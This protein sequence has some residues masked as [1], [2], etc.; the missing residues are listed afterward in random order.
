MI[1][2]VMD[3]TK[4]GRKMPRE[5]GVM[6]YRSSCPGCLKFEISPRRR[7]G[8]RRDPHRGNCQRRSVDD[9]LRKKNHGLWL[10]VLAFART[11][12]GAH[13]RLPFPGNGS[14]TPVLISFKI[15]LVRT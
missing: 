4:L 5:R 1:K 15:M 8:E 2:G 11:T 6:F 12:E 3:D 9:V 13:L 10:W 7:P 14:A